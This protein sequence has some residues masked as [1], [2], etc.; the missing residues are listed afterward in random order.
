MRKF[1]FVRH[2]QSTGNVGLPT[3]RPANIPL[4]NLGRQ[5]A[6]AI[7][8]C[9]K[10]PPSLIVYSPY[11]RARQTAQLAGQHCHYVQYEKWDV[12]EFTYLSIEGNEDTTTAQRHPQ[13]VKFWEQAD[14]LYRMSED[15]ESF[16]DLL[17][18]AQHTLTRLESRQDAFVVIFSHE[19]FIRA[20]MWILSHDSLTMTSKEMRLFWASL[21]DLPMPNGAILPVTMAS[22]HKKTFGDFMTSHLEP[23]L[24]DFST[25]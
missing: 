16:A 25:I 15:V 4:T 17:Q 22:D 19:Q 2:G 10:Q 23:C 8:Q 5:Q 11:L 9:F 6:T 24:L 21:K 12:Q 14:P 20:I 13:V 3:S 18:R 1:W 7:A